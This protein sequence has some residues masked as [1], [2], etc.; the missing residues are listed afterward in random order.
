MLPLCFHLHFYISYAFSF[1]QNSIISILSYVIFLITFSFSEVEN[2]QVNKNLMDGVRSIEKECTS[3]IIRCKYLGNAI[4]S[5]CIGS[6]Y[7]DSVLMTFTLD[8]Q[9]GLIYFFT[10]HYLTFPKHANLWQA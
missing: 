8:F 10:V 9:N 6:V 7:F 5:V 3:S 2:H 4:F 1:L